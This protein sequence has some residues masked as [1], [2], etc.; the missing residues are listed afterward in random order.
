MSEKEKKIKI[1]DVLEHGNGAPQLTYTMDFG[2]FG[3]QTETK[4]FEP[5]ISEENIK[6]FLRKQYREVLEGLKNPM[7]KIDYK[8]L[9][10]GEEDN[11]I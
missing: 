11:V 7:P 9:K 10:C 5:S 2:E 1:I 4:I 8:K 3:K 6:Y